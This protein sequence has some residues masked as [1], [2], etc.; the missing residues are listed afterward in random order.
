MNVEEI[1][2]DY[3]VPYNFYISDLIHI[4]VTFLRTKLVRSNTVNNPSVVQGVLAVFSTL[5]WIYEQNI[6]CFGSVSHY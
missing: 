6:Y 2:R 1:I 4:C 3:I 5:F